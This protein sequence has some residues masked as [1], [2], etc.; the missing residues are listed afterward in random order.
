MPKFLQTFRDVRVRPNEVKI[1]NVSITI[2]RGKLKNGTKVYFVPW[3]MASLVPSP[4]VQQ[5]SNACKDPPVCKSSPFYERTF[6]MLKWYIAKNICLFVEDT[7]KTYAYEEVVNNTITHLFKEFGSYSL[8]IMHI[9]L[10]YCEFLHT[11]LEVDV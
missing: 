4:Y 11:V 1:G 7:P 3:E 8:C 9:E 5:L 2:V 10:E 6:N